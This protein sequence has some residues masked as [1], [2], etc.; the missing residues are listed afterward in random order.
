MN[1]DWSKP[2]MAT[3]FV[4]DWVLRILGKIFLLLDKKRESPKLSLSAA[5]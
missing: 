3:F 1:K 2:V 5:Y 4:S